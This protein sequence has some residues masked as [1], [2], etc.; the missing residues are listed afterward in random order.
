MLGFEGVEFCV[1]VMA[2]R[3][4]YEAWDGLDCCHSYESLKF[5]CT[6]YEAMLTQQITIASL[7]MVVQKD[8]Q[9]TIILTR[10]V[11]LF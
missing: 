10:S 9:F 7:Q 1:M 8:V 5:V 2:H 3:S 11:I 4:L 6:N